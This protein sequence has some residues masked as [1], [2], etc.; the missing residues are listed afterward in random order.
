MFLSQRKRFM[1]ILI[2][3]LNLIFT[4]EVRSVKRERWRGNAGS[5]CFNLYDIGHGIEIGLNRQ[6]VLCQQETNEYLTRT[7]HR[8]AQ[9]TGSIRNVNYERISAN[10]RLRKTPTAIEYP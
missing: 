2:G 5:S 6:T 4:C 8:R 1:N 10:S 3:L 9:Y 7:S